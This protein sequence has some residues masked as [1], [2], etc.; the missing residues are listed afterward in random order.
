MEGKHEPIVRILESSFCD[1][2]LRHPCMNRATTF[3]LKLCFMV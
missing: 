2:T 1:V 3:P